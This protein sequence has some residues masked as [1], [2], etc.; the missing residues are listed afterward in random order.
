MAI[1]KGARNL[2]TAKKFFDWALT[3]EA[4]KIGLD[5]KEYAIPTNRSVPLPPQVP[6]LTD[7]KVI[8]YDFAK[9]GSSDDAQAPAR[10]LGE[11]D[12]RGARSDARCSPDA[13]APP[14]ARLLLWLAVGA[15]GFLLRAVVRAA[16]LVLGIAWLRDYA[17]KDNAPALLQAI[18]PRSRRGCSPIGRA[19]ARGPAAARP[20][21]RAALARDGLIA[22]RRRRLRLPRRAG[23]RHRP[24]RLGVRFARPACSAPLATGQYGMGWGAALVATAFAMLFALGLAERGYFKGDAFVA[25]SVVAI[26]LLGGDLHVLSR[27][28]R[29]WSRRVRGR[30]RRAFA[31][32]VLRPPVHRKRSGAWAASSGGDA[33]RR[34]LEHAAARAAVRGRLH[35]AGARLRAD[36]H[37][38]ELPLQEDAARRCRCCRS[39]RR[40]S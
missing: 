33:L 20:A 39:S 27:S 5:V 21:S 2:D 13:C 9:Y 32:G 40:R 34:R 28:S 1:I 23:L 25:G 14:H 31:D 18:A 4:Q 19:A 38:H 3:P 8:D 24:A 6:K 12:Q 36:R 22:R 15:V 17:A 10:A 7:I 11:G 30:R 37:A 26:A 35:G 29:S 16:G